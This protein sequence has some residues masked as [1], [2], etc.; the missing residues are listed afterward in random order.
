[1]HEGIFNVCYGAFECLY[2][3]SLLLRFQNQ[4][5][6][7]LVVS[8][9][10]EI[11]L[12]LDILSGNHQNMQVCNELIEHEPKVQHFCQTSI[13][14]I[15]LWYLILPPNFLGETIAKSYESEFREESIY[16]SHHGN[17]I[18]IADWLDNMVM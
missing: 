7:L 5:D 1:M 6:L 8:E 9:M 4:V 17:F 10:S 11:G 3:A 15:R 12:D 16:I 18:F 14:Q 2:K 13:D